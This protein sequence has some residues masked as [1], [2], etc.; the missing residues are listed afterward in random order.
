MLSTNQAI[1]KFCIT[2]LQQENTTGATGGVGNGY[3]FAS[4][5]LLKGYVLFNLMFF[6]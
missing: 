3:P 1:N 5:L 6:A 2:D 4:S